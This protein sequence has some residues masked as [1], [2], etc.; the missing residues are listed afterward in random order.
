MCQLGKEAARQTLIYS[1]AC[2]LA[3]WDSSSGHGALM[4]TDRRHIGHNVQPRGY[5]PPTHP[6]TISP[7][8]PLTHPPTHPPYHSSTFALPFQE[9]LISAKV[10]VVLKVTLRAT[11]GYARRNGHTEKCLGWEGV[12]LKRHN[13]C[14]RPDWISEELPP[15]QFP[16]QG[17][18]TPFSSDI[19]TMHWIQKRVHSFVGKRQT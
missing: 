14:R 8:H 19:M 3:I 12:S 18:K 6:L 2:A 5:S 7:T 11:Q 10:K 15:S 17:I 4:P 9:H 1:N 16:L 13:V